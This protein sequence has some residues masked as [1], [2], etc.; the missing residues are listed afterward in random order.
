MKTRWLVAVWTG[1]FLVAPWTA[2]SARDMDNSG[3]AYG[4]KM[5]LS[6]GQKTKLKALHRTERDALTPLKDKQED[7]AKKLR[8]QVDA[9]ASDAVIQP[10]LEEL[11][12]NQKAM[13]DQIEK[14]QTQ[15]ETILTPTQQ[16]EMLLRFMKH[17]HMKF[18]RH[19]DRSGKGGPKERRE[20]E[21][22][23]NNEK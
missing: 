18:S 3:A 9:K 10:I 19:G 11:K 13:R 15:R 6:D 16:A 23:P 12:S 14:F 4:S 8:T 1:L 17:D 21:H 20:P 22:E 2:A 7:L 5:D